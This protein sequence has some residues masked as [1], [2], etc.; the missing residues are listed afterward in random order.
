[1][2]KWYIAGYGFGRKDDQPAFAGQVKRFQAEHAADAADGRVDRD[3]LA[4]QVD[5][6]VALAGDFIEDRTDT[7]AGRITDDVDVLGRIQ[8]GFDSPP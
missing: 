5:A 1:V 3:G 2:T 6:D 8:H 4:V 7:A